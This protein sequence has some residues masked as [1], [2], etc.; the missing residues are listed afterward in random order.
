MSKGHNSASSQTVRVTLSA[1]SIRLLDQLATRGIWG[2]NRAEV[3]ARFV[4][5]ALQK[6][7]EQ[8]RLQLDDQAKGRL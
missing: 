8:P 2:R 4:D 6:L 1:Q 7:V 5:E 3:A